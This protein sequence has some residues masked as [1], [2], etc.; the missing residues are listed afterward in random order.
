MRRSTWLGILLFCLA[1]VMTN[2]QDPLPL[3]L[4]QPDELDRIEISNTSALNWYKTDQLLNLLPNFTSASGSYASKQPFQRGTFVLKNGRRIN[5]M[6]NSAD[7][8]LLYEGS[9]EQLYVLPKSPQVRDPAAPL[10]P[11][12]AEQGKAGYIDVNGNP[13]LPQFNAVGEFSEGLAPVM[14]GDKWG[15]ID[16]AGKVVIAPRWKNNEGWTGAVAPFHEGLA[17]VTEYASWGVRDDSNY[18][19]YKCG[20][21]DKSGN[22]V[23]KPVMR[24]SCGNFSDGL[25]AIE[26][27]FDGSEDT[28]SGGWT[29]YID[30]KGN[31]VI[32]PKYVGGS[33]FYQ[34]LAFVGEEMGADHG[35]YKTH[36]IDKQGNAV[37]GVSDCRWRHQFYGGLALSYNETTKRY[38]GYLNEKCELAIKLPPDILVDPQYSQFSEGLAAVYRR[39]ANWTPETNEDQNRWGYLDR[40]G[41]LVIPF[42]FEKAE[43]F[44]DGLA[45]VK[46]G[47]R[48]GYINPQGALVITMSVGS[49]AAFQHGLAYQYLFTWTISESRDGRNIRGY[50]N[51]AGKYVWL[52]PR[53]EVYLDKKWILENY[54]GPQKFKFRE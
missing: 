22:Y 36:L 24:Q 10:F 28:K 14:I 20:Y 11:V 4:P 53:A 54:V 12:W 35:G 50:M 21:I 27:D 31:W 47:E 18:W 8:L 49:A 23:I 19:T 40:T 25:A 38:D 32:K 51:K 13:A 7:S 17:A 33:S 29:G 52:A 16:R 41:K 46:N 6:A 30:T 9:K 43:P 3:R 2:A 1:S 37:E 48:E 34:G 39:P 44:S 45:I 15:Y 5:W 42:Q 26:I